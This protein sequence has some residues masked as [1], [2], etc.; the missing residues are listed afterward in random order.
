MKAW[1][2]PRGLAGSEGVPLLPLASVFLECC[3]HPTPG[4]C[5]INKRTGE[6]PIALQAR[7]GSHEERSG[8][9]LLGGLSSRCPNTAEGRQDTARRQSYPPALP[10]QGEEGGFLREASIS[11]YRHIPSAPHPFLLLPLGGGVG[12][13]WRG[14]VRGL[15]SCSPLCC[16][17]SRLCGPSPE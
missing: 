8:L 1:A 15:R 13:R 17:R 6:C 10:C 11:S 5:R 2:S 14:V 3:D 7:R 16:L 9:R 4:C 12:R